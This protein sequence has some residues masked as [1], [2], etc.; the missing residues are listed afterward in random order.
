[1]ITD[2][3]AH[4]SRYAALHPDFAEAFRLLQSLDL[5]ALPDDQV[6]CGNPIYAEHDDDYLAECLANLHNK[7]I[8]I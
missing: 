8:A 6:P 7:G 1:M 4:A 3:I 2:T 5:A